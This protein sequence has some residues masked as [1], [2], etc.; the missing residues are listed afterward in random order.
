MADDDQEFEI[1]EQPG[2]SAVV[3]NSPST[4]PNSPYGRINREISEEDLNNPALQRVLLSQLDQKESRVNELEE[5]ATDF[6]KIDKQCAVQ[7]EKLK[8]LKSH[9]VLYSFCLS[10]GSVI[11]GITTSVW[12]E[13]Y[14][15]ITLVIGSLLIIG[16]FLSS[17]DKQ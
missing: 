9:N 6:H 7:N 8:A 2:A 13:G 5:M 15:L 17:K 3:T 12:D 10:I 11:I 14:G 1:P 4:I 16:S